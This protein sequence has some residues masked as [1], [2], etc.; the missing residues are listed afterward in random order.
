MKCRS[1][2]QEWW[3]YWCSYLVRRAYSSVNQGQWATLLACSTIGWRF[4]EGN[5]SAKNNTPLLLDSLSPMPHHL[6]FSFLSHYLFQFCVNLKNRL[7]HLPHFTTHYDW[8]TRRDGRLLWQISPAFFFLLFFL[9]I[10]GEFETD[11]TTPSKCY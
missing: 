8:F 9:L 10:F 3:C 2:T 5:I 6:H 11:L 4:D 7:Y 1:L